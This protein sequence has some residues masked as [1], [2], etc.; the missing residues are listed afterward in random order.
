MSFPNH[1]GRPRLVG[2]SLPRN[3][4]QQLFLTLK[5]SSRSG[6][7]GHRGRP[8]HQGGSTSSFI[9]KAVFIDE[10]V[11]YPLGKKLS[12]LI[13]ELSSSYP[14]EILPEIKKVYVGGTMEDLMDAA[15]KEGQSLEDLEDFQTAAGAY[16]KDTKALGITTVLQSKEDIAHFL[17]HEVGHAIWSK[18]EENYGSGVKGY[19]IYHS[20]K[21]DFGRHTDYSKKDPEESFCETYNLYLRDKG[22]LSKDEIDRVEY[23]LEDI[24]HYSE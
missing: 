16:F 22:K 20:I 23:V 13:T 24:G 7:F 17:D 4:L 1:K 18:A 6:N 12:D 9:S 3:N 14:S 11:E 15:L 21:P 10:G 2:G 19:E 8:G 5:G